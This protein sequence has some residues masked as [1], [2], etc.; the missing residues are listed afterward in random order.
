[1][2]MKFL[3][4]CVGLSFWSG[5]L[6]EN[7]VSRGQGGGGTEGVA[8][9][10]PD[11]V[12]SFEYRTWMPLT[13][14]TWSQASQTRI[15]H[16]GEVLDVPKGAALEM[17]SKP[18]GWIAFVRAQQRLG[19]KALSLGSWMVPYVQ[20]QV[21]VAADSL[22][23]DGTPYGA[24]C[25]QGIC[26]LDQIPQDYLNVELYVRGI[27]YPFFLRDTCCQQVQ[28]PSPIGVVPNQRPV[29]EW[30]LLAEKNGD[31]HALNWTGE[32]SNQ[33][34]WVYI[35]TLVPNQM[36][37][38]HQ[39]DQE[40]DNGEVYR[41][42]V[43]LDLK[44]DPGVY[45]IPLQQSSLKAQKPLL[46]LDAQGAFVNFLQDKKSTFKMTPGQWH[47]L[48]YTVDLVDQKKVEVWVDGWKVWSLEAS[49]PSAAL[50]FQSASP[51][52][53]D[54]WALYQYSTHTGQMVFFGTSPGFKVGLGLS[55]MALYQGVLSDREI[56]A[57]GAFTRP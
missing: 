50:D 32:L 14:S 21:Y 26:V 38:E 1:M 28:I 17:K 51:E 47:R 53:W 46:S 3:W 30:S 19:A 13:D 8:V 45:N 31:T 54:N 5:C 18:Q 49:L 15:W 33:G 10:V 27:K 6:W 44:T 2:K 43:L 48:V 12:V 34:T 39:L 57:L 7:H 23:L 37:F 52:M 42:T 20:R 56:A 24:K 36:W 29:V 25:A 35:D 40:G 16:R 22:V 55:H 41:Y 9:E 11:S 4:I